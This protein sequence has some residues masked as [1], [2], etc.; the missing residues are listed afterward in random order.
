MNDLLDRHY[1]AISNF[2]FIIKEVTPV[3]FQRLAV[4]LLQ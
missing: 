1:N 2:L 3:A 4:L